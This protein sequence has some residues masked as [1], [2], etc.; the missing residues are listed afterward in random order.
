MLIWLVSIA[1][2]VNESNRHNFVAYSHSAIVLVLLHSPLT[3]P[4]SSLAENWTLLQNRFNSAPEVI[5]ADADCDTYLAACRTF[6]PSRAWPLIVRYRGRQ[7]TPLD[8][9]TTYESLVAYTSSIIDSHRHVQCPPYPNDNLDFPA[10]VFHASSGH[11]CVSVR[12]FLRMN[13]NRASRVYWANDTSQFEF[14]VKFSA[15]ESA[16]YRS[17]KTARDWAEFVREFT[18]EPLGPWSRVSRAFSR[19]IGFLVFKSASDLDVY[20]PFLRKY[21]DLAYFARILFPDF[22]AKFPSIQLK[23]DEVPAIGVG[24]KRH[25]FRLFRNADLNSPEFVSDFEQAV[26]GKIDDTMKE[27]MAPLGLKPLAVFDRRYFQVSVVIAG[28][29]ILLTVV[30]IVRKARKCVNRLTRQVGRFVL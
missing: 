25:F 28:V 11:I 10:F 12:H 9:S 1:I 29:T 8:I 26:A 14:E 22:T 20:R 18:L 5:I 3:N 15:N 2:H 4:S 13:S 19:R 23:E 30:M 7:G 6:F 17:I 27:S 21:Q 24:N 16:I